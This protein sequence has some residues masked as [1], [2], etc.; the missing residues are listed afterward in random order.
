MNGAKNAVVYC[1]ARDEPILSHTHTLA[2]CVVHCLVHPLLL[3]SR[4]SFE[5]I[6]IIII[7]IIKL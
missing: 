5:V 7:I 4:P 3:V 2:H 1:T 6:I